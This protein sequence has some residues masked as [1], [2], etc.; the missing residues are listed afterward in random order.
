VSSGQRVVSLFVRPLAHAPD[1]VPAHAV[2]PD[3]PGVVLGAEAFV[4]AAA[5]ALLGAGGGPPGVV[6]CLGTVA[7]LPAPGLATRAARRLAARLAGRDHA[8]VARGRLV[9][10]TADEPA[11]VPR[12][13]AASAGMPTVLAALGP[14]DTALDELI[15]YEPAV[16]AAPVGADPALAELALATLPRGSVAI[17]IG[18][19]GV[20]RA[21]ATAGWFAGPALRRALEPALRVPA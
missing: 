4:V 17:P 21:L 2:A 14:R 20:E 6:V 1:A 8:A 19:P 3:G 9:V 11:Q 15:G 7:E 10:A 5:L 16:V 18:A 12:I 13:I